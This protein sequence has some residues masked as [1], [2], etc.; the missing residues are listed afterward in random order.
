MVLNLKT[1]NT[2]NFL[3]NNLK[4]ND[5][6]VYD[7]EVYKNYFLLCYTVVS[8]E[9]DKIINKKEDLNIKY[10]DSRD[11]NFADE[12]YKLFYMNVNKLQLFVGYNN[13]RYDNYVI[14][15]IMKNR[16]K[17]KENKNQF[18]QDLK[19]VSDDIILNNERQK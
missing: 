7:I 8:S 6:L 9:K 13:S 18:L 10:I 11:D 5:I 1:I 2:N 15:Y 14:A 3:L 19:Q 12:I 17:A 16:Q 4:I